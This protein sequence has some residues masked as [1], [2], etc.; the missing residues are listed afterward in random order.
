[1]GFKARH[2]HSAY[3]VEVTNLKSEKE[4]VYFKLDSGA[5]DTVVAFETLYGKDVS[6]DALI[7]YCAEKNIKKHTFYSVSGNSMEGYY[8]VST[9]VSMGGFRLEKFGYYLIINVNNNVALLGDDFLIHCHYVH[10]PYG[11]IVVEAVMADQY[12]KEM[13]E[14]IEKS[15]I[16]AILGLSN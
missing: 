6:K 16:N 3:S 15:R 8:T 2:V 5:S 14:P 10:E 7:E 1:M 9:D 13:K 11:G 12:G 4:V